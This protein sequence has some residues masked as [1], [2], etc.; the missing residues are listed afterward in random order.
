[1]FNINFK[2]PPGIV[3][4]RGGGGGGGGGGSGEGKNFP[5]PTYFQLYI[6]N[7]FFSFIFSWIF[8]QNL[9]NFIHFLFLPPLHSTAYAY[10]RLEG[11]LSLYSLTL[12]F[13]QHCEIP[14]DDA[15][16]NPN[17]QMRQNF[18]EAN[19]VILKISVW[20]PG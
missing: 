1:M 7:T 9:P 18:R 13:D 17:S 2:F 11:L 19:F 16:Q 5:D 6:F 3:G 4:A 12:I 10:T 14:F 15:A 20:G 8:P